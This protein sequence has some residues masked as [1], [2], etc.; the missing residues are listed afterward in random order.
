MS[1][2][3]YD[4]SKWTMIT[5]SSIAI[6]LTVGLVLLSTAHGQNASSSMVDVYV[7]CVENLT[8]TYEKCTG[9]SGPLKQ[10]IV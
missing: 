5:L 8:N 3:C 6:S 4:F 2:F 7:D 1:L 10:L 9:L